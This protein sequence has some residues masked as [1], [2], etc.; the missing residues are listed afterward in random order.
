M[1]YRIF[2]ILIFTALFSG[3]RDDV[4]TAQVPFHDDGRAKPIVLLI[5]VIDTT[6]N[7]L[8]WNLSEEISHGIQHR[9]MQSKL[10]FLCNQKRLHTKLLQE[11]NPF[12]ISCDWLKNFV[13]NEE[14][15][16]FVELI[17]HEEKP[18][19]TSE[20]G[21]DLHMSIRLRIFDVRNAQVKVILQEVINQSHFVPKHYMQGQFAQVAWGEEGY[22]YSPMG[23]AHQH[24]IKEIASRL[25]DYILI[26]KSQ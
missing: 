25:E 19:I 2:V 7:S 15:I 14:F 10:L 1:I 13:T 5:P 16:A 8:A 12:D 11:H 22:S 6:D 18:H 26:A 4:N 20:N 3:C 21:A 17:R 23:S 9:L 24:L